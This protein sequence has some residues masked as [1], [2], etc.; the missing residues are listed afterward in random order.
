VTASASGAVVN[1]VNDAP[2]G[3]ANTKLVESIVNDSFLLIGM[4]GGSGYDCVEGTACTADDDC[5]PNQSLVCDFGLL[6]LRTS[7]A[8]RRASATRRESRDFR[9][10]WWTRSSGRG[11]RRARPAAAAVEAAVGLEASVASRAACGITPLRCST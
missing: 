9:P 8:Q 10:L 2:G 5:S 7:C 1:L 6:R 3:F 11:L 4:S